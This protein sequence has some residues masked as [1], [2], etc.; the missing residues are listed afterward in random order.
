MRDRKLA[1]AGD[2]AQPVTLKTGLAQRV[3]RCAARRVPTTS[4]PASWARWGCS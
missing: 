1:V 2:T 4:G 3:R